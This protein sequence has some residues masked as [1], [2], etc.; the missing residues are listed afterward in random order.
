MTRRSELFRHIEPPPG[1]LA[2]LRQ[3]L[4]ARRRR[5]AWLLGVPTLAAA[6]CA[7]LVLGLRTPAPDPVR[8][9][10]LADPMAYSLGLRPA[11]GEAVA[12]EGD[13]VLTRLPSSDPKVSV[14]WVDAVGR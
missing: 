8:E 6:A 1:G 5:R 9:Q 7:A 4:E 3:K 2:L 14:Y 10:L 11:L 12:G 13:T